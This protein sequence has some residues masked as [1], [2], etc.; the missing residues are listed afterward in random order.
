MPS[1]YSTHKQNLPASVSSFIGR[2]QELREVRQRLREHRLITLT[3]T[4]DRVAMVAQK[5]AYAYAP[6]SHKGASTANCNPTRPL[7]HGTASIRLQNRA[8]NE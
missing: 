7:A 4:G 6:G 5:R 2:E 8:I 3:G 1:E